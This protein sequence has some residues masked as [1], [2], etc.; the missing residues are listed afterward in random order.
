MELRENNFTTSLYSS[1]S[2]FVK[3]LTYL[4]RKVLY[5]RGYHGGGRWHVV[6]D[7]SPLNGLPPACFVARGYCLPSCFMPR[8]PRGS[9]AESPEVQKNVAVIVCHNKVLIEVSLFMYIMT[10]YVEYHNVSRR[11]LENR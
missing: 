6:G 3:V 5:C 7:G 9:L 10:F 1:I 2:L 11:R 4:D 8:F